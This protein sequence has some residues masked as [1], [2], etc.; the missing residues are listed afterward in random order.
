MAKRLDNFEFPSPS[1]RPRKYPWDE[2]LDGFA[3][4]VTQ[5]EDFAVSIDAFRSMFYGAC[6][7]RGLLG[8]SSVS[9]D[10]VTFQARPK[11][12]ETD[13]VQA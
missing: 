5:D 11:G 6:T 4:Q 3:W 10:T 8:R 7:R 9:G 2:W 12:A 13:G 1:G